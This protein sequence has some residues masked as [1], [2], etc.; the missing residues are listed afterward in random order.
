MPYIPGSHYGKRP[1][2]CEDCGEKD[3]YPVHKINDEPTVADTVCYRCYE[4]RIVLIK[5]RA[6]AHRSAWW[7]KGYYTRL[8]PLNQMRRS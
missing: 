8:S 5:Q 2:E 4:H 3:I 7:E 1:G 6:A